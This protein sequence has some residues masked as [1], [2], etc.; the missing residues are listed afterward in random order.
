MARPLRPELPGAVDRLTAR[1]NARLVVERRM[2]RVVQERAV[3]EDKTRAARL[4]ERMFNPPSQATVEKPRDIGTA[5]DEEMA[6]RKRVQAIFDLALDTVMLF[7]EA[8]PA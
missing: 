3:L 2:A 1:G 5:I 8:Q 4:N 7:D 6:D